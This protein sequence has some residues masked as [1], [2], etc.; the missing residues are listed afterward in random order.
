MDCPL[1]SIGTI[2]KRHCTTY[3]PDRLMF[4]A[5][6]LSP[7]E[8]VLATFEYGASAA[9]LRLMNT[10][11]DGTDSAEIKAARQVRWI[12]QRTLRGPLRDH[13]LH[14][15]SQIE[16]SERE[17][18]SL[19]QY[20]A[21]V[22]N[23][24]RRLFRLIVEARGGNIERAGEVGGF[25]AEATALQ[26]MLD[27]RL[28]NISN[29]H[30][31]ALLMEAD[32]LRGRE[33]LW[34]KRARLRFLFRDVL[35]RKHLASVGRGSLPERVISSKWLIGTLRLLGVVAIPILMRLYFTHDP[36]LAGGDVVHVEAGIGTTVLGILLLVALWYCASQS[37]VIG[38]R[39]SGADDATVERYRQVTRSRCW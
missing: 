3:L 4:A 39:C 29:G 2:D 11:R 9:L 38:L 28:A 23:N 10:E 35:T 20:L 22:G 21:M 14:A 24:G 37:Q 27:T 7:W 25:L 6:G 34:E 18:V 32:C 36:P 12:L 30:Y 15:N 8:A 1:M 26:H 5:F 17:Q 33:L 16:A 19:D 31:N 13:V